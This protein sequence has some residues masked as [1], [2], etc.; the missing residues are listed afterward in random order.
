[1]LQ[2]GAAAVMHVKIDLDLFG[3]MQ[4]VYHACDLQ[5]YVPKQ[6][7]KHAGHPKG[8]PACINWAG[9]SLSSAES[10]PDDDR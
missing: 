2:R 9:I 8:G 4:Y 1:M 3:L 7:V 5:S 6:A 10:Q